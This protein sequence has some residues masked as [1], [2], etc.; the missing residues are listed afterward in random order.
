MDNHSELHNHL[1]ELF[2]KRRNYLQVLKDQIRQYQYVVFYGCGNIFHGI[3]A[4]W[5]Q[6]VGKRIDL[7]CDSD[8]EKWGKEFSGIK[9]ISPSELIKIKNECAVFV[10]IGEFKQVFCFAVTENNSSL[11]SLLNEGLAIISNNGIFDAL[12]KFNDYRIILQ[13]ITVTFN[14]KNY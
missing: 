12:Y 10:T 3:V 2:A 7:C 4:S 1:V 11:L 13:I 8:S 9:C 6:Q 14:R 5:N